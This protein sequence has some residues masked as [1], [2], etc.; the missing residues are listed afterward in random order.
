VGSAA[1]LG[2]AGATFQIT[3]C[4]MPFVQ[5]LITVID[6]YTWVIIIGVILSW[7]LTFGVINGNNQVVRAVYNFCA[8]LTEPPL[9]MIRR[10]IKPF[11]G[12]DLSPI[13]LILLLRLVQYCLAYYVVP[14]LM[15]SGL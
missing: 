4:A 9:R 1:G 12:V 14:P 3:G 6:L 8:A 10:H 5:L 11:N 2:Y 15:R 13:V 7:L